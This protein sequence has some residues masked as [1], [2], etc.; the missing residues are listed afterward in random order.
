MRAQQ[1]LTSWRK[2]LQLGGD[3]ALDKCVY[4]YMGW[5]REKGREALGSIA[6]FPGTINI[7]SNC[8]DNTTINRIEAWDSE[9]ILGV[10]CGLDGS[11]DRELQYR[12]QEAQ[13]LAGRIKTA[14]LTRFDS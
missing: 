2:L 6:Q 7:E 9:R 12:I 1:V 10:R 8:G 11:D 3:L 13:T 14:P 5:T 4:S